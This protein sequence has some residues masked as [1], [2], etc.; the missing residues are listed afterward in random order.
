MP[1]WEETEDLLKTLTIVAAIALAPLACRAAD[2]TP[3]DVKTGLWETTIN[4]QTSGVPGVSDDVLAKM[5]PE[6]R[7]RIEAAIKGASGP[8]TT[9]SCVTPDTL[10]SAAF[11]DSSNSACKR[12]LISSTPTSATYHV[13]C[14]SGRMTNVGD[15]HVQATSSE[16]IK[17]DVVMKT[18]M[19]G[20]RTSTTNVT[21]TA[22][23][24]GSDCGSL[25]PK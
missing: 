6:Q 17:G 9:R 22:H 12:T 21:F 19:P 7:A 16:S 20:G 3:L 14:G 10:K 11:G 25:K 1:S 5:P 13:E 8:H 2:L 18:T 4:T 15:G 23:W 24:L